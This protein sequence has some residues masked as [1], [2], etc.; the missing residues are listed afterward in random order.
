MNH[1]YVL[2]QFHISLVANYPIDDNLTTEQQ[3]CSF[4]NTLI[5]N[6]HHT[7]NKCDVKKVMHGVDKFNFY[8][9]IKCKQSAL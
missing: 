5:T 9:R 2:V 6:K 7:N 3:Y 1:L 4:S 8:L